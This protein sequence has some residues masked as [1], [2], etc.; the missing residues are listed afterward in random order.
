MRRSETQHV[1]QI[2][3]D[4]LSEFQLG[5]KIKEAR[6]LNAWDE[7][8]GSYIRSHTV[9]TY[10]RNSILFVEFDSAVIRNELFM[11]REQL[12]AK[13]NEAAG[14]KVIEKIVFK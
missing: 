1:G 5:R 3:E 14:S 4:L 11:M 6:I 2:L 9:K 10:I 8:V 13:L 12:T 7:V